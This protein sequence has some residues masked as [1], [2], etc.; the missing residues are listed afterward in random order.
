MRRFAFTFMALLLVPAL[1]WGQAQVTGRVAGKVVDEEGRPMAEVR[2]TLLSPAMQGER[3]VTTNENG[4]FLAALLPVGPYL[5]TA[6][7][8][9]KQP[10]EVSFRVGVGRRCRWTIVLTPGEQLVEQVTV[11]GTLSKLET[12]SVG[13]NFNYR[14]QVEDLPIQNRQLERVAQYAPNV[15]LGINNSLAVSGAMTTDTVVLLDG[16]EISD[17]YFSAGPV[18]YFEDAIEEVQVL[19]SGVSARYG[20]FQGGVVNAITRTGGNTFTGAARVE[21]TKE[22]WNS[23]TPFGESQSD[24]LNKVYQGRWAGTS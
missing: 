3:V 19:T 7:A 5:A 12:T 21:L 16:S 4:Q 18:L 15:T 14:T 24:N 20:R 6:T 13:E 23:Q 22:S 2:V 1:A 11:L 8:P 9:G 17:P 10:V